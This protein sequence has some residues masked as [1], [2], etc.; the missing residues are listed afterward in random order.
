MTLAEH[1][2]KLCLKHPDINS[3]KLGKMLHEINPETIPLKYARKVIRRC[4]KQD[5]QT[6]I[7]GIAVFRKSFT[8]E[9]KKEI[10]N[11]NKSKIRR[12]KKNM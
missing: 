3:N 9:Y 11:E 2:Y 7:N 6:K 8:V 4:R 10:N 12:N 1:A 5:Y